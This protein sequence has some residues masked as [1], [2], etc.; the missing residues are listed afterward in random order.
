MKKE[1]IKEGE[2]I[3]EKNQH[4]H[5]GSGYWAILLII[6]GTLFL[7]NNLDLLPSDTRENLWK[8][9]PLFLIYWGLQT[10]FKKTWLSNLLVMLLTLAIVYFALSYLNPDLNSLFNQRFHLNLPGF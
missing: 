8:L 6:L 2:V 9:W 1:D 10:L 4:Y 5:G 3:E 7:L